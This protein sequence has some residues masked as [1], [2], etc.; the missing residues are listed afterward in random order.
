MWCKA[1]KMTN[2]HV[3]IVTMLVFG[4]STFHLTK[5]SL[6]SSNS[7]EALINKNQCSEINNTLC[8]SVNKWLKKTW[9]VVCKM[10]V[11]IDLPTT[12]S[13]KSW[14]S[15]NQQHETAIFSF[16][17]LLFLHFGHCRNMNTILT[18]KN[19]CHLYVYICNLISPK[20]QIP[21]L[22]TY[23]CVQVAITDLK[24]RTLG[25]SSS[26]GFIHPCLQVFQTSFNKLLKFLY[27]FYSKYHVL[28]PWVSQNR[29]SCWISGGKFV[30]KN[31][32]RQ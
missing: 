4:T 29:Q 13:S 14:W 19:S 16:R 6:N 11:M 30:R 8:S 3:Q 12:I 23:T 25:G 15:H 31:L 28:H 24:F 22:E 5:G 10:I 1:P 9:L 27:S 20:L 21:C 26:C 2:T 18:L 7:L 32:P 17:Y